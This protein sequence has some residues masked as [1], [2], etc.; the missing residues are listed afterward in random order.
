MAPIDQEGVALLGSMALLEEVH[1]Y[2]VGFEVSEAEA[3]SVSHSL[4]LLSDDLD[5]ELSAPSP[6][7]SLPVYHHASLHDDNGLNF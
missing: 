5:V 2:R 6:A 7:L 1:H 4:F 3:R